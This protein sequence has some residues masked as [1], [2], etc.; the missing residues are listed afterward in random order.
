MMRPLLLISYEIHKQYYVC[1]ICSG[2]RRRWQSLCE[3]AIAFEETL[4]WS[5]MVRDSRHTQGDRASLYAGV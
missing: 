1:V 5:V 4:D 3:F 2:K